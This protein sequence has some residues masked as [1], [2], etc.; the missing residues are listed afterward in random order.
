MKNTC[1]NFLKRLLQFYK[2]I[3]K[4]FFVF[5][6]DIKKDFAF[7]NKNTELLAVWTVLFMIITGL[8]IIAIKSS[9]LAMFLL[10]MLSVAIMFTGTFVAMYYLHALKYHHK[11]RLLPKIHNLLNKSFQF[12]SLLRYIKI[13]HISIFNNLVKNFK[14]AS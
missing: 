10:F 3:E 1:F 5:I 14:L 9:I 13:P 12:R 11:K 2:K 6:K 7:H 8:F 4:L